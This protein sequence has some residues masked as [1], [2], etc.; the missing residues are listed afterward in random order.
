MKEIALFVAV[1]NVILV[2]IHS[3]AM[4]KEAAKCANSKLDGFQM[5]M[6][7]IHGTIGIGSMLVNY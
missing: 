1:F 5:C 7:A 4:G 6:I 2:G 3:Y